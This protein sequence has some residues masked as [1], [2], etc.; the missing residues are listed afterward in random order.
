MLCLEYCGRI[1]CAC[2]CPWISLDYLT[3][4]DLV[5]PYANRSEPTLAQVMAWCRLPDGTKP[6]PDPSWLFISKFQWH[7]FEVNFPRY[8]SAISYQNIY[9]S[10]IPFKSRGQW[11]WVNKIKKIFNPCLLQC[12][13]LFASE[14]QAINSRHLRRSLMEHTYFDWSKVPRAD[15]RRLSGKSFHSP[16]MLTTRFR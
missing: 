15:E 12:S 6:L 2:W 13:P 1:S 3:H 5:T 9:L 10:K 16:Q 11:D 8:T 14:D 4:C 7:S